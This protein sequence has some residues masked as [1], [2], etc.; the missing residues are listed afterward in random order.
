[1]GGRLL[2]SDTNSFEEMK[3]EI[4]RLKAIDSKSYSLTAQQKQHVNRML[5]AGT[6]RGQITAYAGRAGTGKTFT[7]SIIH[8]RRILEDQKLAASTDT[9]TNE[10]PQWDFFAELIID[11]RGVDFD[12]DDYGI[13]I[14]SSNAIPLS[15]SVRDEM[16]YKESLH[17]VDIGSMLGLTQLDECDVDVGI[18][19]YVFG[20]SR[21]MGMDMFIPDDV[22]SKRPDNCYELISRQKYEYV[23]EEYVTRENEDDAID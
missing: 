23:D 6:R 21:H 13:E 16:I 3:A 5:R 18:F 19:R 22:D 7:G 8:R 11:T 14:V 10:Y 9:H 1:M 2:H 20:A 17:Q 12:A 4:L 15:G